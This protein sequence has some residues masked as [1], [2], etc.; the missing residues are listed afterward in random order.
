MVTPDVLP[1]ADK[2]LRLPTSVTIVCSG[3]DPAAHG[4]SAAA[5]VGAPKDALNTAA[6]TTEVLGDR[7]YVNWRPSGDIR[8][9]AVAK[10]LEAEGCTNGL[11]QLESGEG[12]T[13]PPG[14]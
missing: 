2:P 4:T 5:V 12:M 9:S 1:F 8:A 7:L 14:R 13:L 3:A 11:Y 6:I 10:F